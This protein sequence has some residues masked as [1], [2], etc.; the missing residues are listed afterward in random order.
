MTCFPPPLPAHRLRTDIH[1]EGVDVVLGLGK[2]VEER[3]H[4]KPRVFE[5]FEAHGWGGRRTLSPPR[6]AAPTAR[7]SAGWG[8]QW[9]WGAYWG[10]SASSHFCCP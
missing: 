4:V 6:E 5:Q 10:L 9:G 7:L 1:H 3:H 8:A 2:L